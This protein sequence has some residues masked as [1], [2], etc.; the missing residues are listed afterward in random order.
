MQMYFFLG[1]AIGIII[2]I[3]AA[4]WWSRNTERRMRTLAKSA[5]RAERLAEIGTMTSGLAHEIKN[6]LSTIGL[7]IQLLHEDLDDMTKRLPQ[8]A[9]TEQELARTQRRFGSLGRETQR[10]KDIL[11]DFLRFAGRVK[12]DPKP[13]DAH[14]LIGELIDF[15]T[16]Q[17]AEARIN[18]RTQFAAETHNL[19]LDG[20]LLKQALL[21]LMIN[22]VQA[23]T[24]ARDK[25]L[26]HGGATELIIR[27]ANSR[28]L[29]QETLQIHITD[30][31]PG[32]TDNAQDKIF[33]PYFST[34]K[35]GT[36]LG[37][38]TSRRIAEEHG[39]H[40]DVHTESGKGTDFIITLPCDTPNT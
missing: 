37:L 38:P 23:M 21:N 13:T 26:P 17:A 40:L 11:E 20:P 36:G 15:F 22:A 31:G 16:P 7:N 2:T 30:T 5:R 4:Y 6:P 29:G 28:E 33:Q 9:Q 34:K 25:S 3:P 39:G 19:N 35:G 32:L 12:L 27:T 14:Q 8:D 18:L 10:L 24:D 1:I